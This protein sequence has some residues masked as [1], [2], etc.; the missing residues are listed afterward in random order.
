V[1]RFARDPAYRRGDLRARVGLGNVD[2]FNLIR[3][4]EPQDE[5]IDEGEG[6]IHGAL[7]SVG[8]PRR[9]RLRCL[10]HRGS[11]SLYPKTRISVRQS[12]HPRPGAQHDG[13]LALA[14]RED[15]ERD[16]AVFVLEDI[17]ALDVWPRFKPSRDD[18]ADRRLGCQIVLRTMVVVGQK[19]CSRTPGGK[20]SERLPKQRRFRTPRP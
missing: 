10:G 9:E 13:P 19:C 17:E 12:A 6:W 18:G 5:V 7:R 11:W 15:L 3:L 8:D 16:F 4:G 20:P 1:E 14:V 2:V